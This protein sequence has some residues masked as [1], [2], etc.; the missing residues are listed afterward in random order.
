M[1][2][3]GFR[4]IASV[5]CRMADSIFEAKLNR[6]TTQNHLVGKFF[7]NLRK[8]GPLGTSKS[9]C[10]VMKDRLDKVVACRR[11]FLSIDRLLYNLWWY[12]DSSFDR[13][14]GTDTSGKI[15]IEKL[16]IESENVKE[17]IY[18]HP[19]SVE[20][21]KYIMDHLT[22]DFGEFEFIDFGSGKGRVLL[23]ASDYGFKKI[24]GV[25]FAI[26]LHRLATKNVDIWERHTLKSSNIETI[27]M[28]AVEFP[29]PN[30]PLVIFFYSPFVGK[31]LEKVLN[32]VLE[33]F[34]INPR[35]IVLIFYGSN[36]QTLELFKA[37]KFKFRE[38]DLP[39]DWS[40]FIQYRGFL[41]TSP[42]VK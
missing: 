31:V 6:H 15:C 37:T 32:N 33:S 22:I 7:H 40:R 16:S 34:A 1:D 19:M 24:I 41:F 13:K 26:E 30:V 39:F 36:P 4:K 5:D 21:C 28:D 9:V 20:V 2:K 10:E 12:L 27:F 35:E 29:I 17:A 3:A 18:Y 25:E 8:H 23:L 14:Y 38:L 11:L 42:R